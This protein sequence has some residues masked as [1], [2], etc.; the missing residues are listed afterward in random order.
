MNI[1]EIIE[2]KRDKEELTK[3]EI[4]YFVNEY[5]AGNIEDY[6]ASSLLMAIYLNGMVMR[7][8]VDLTI[9]MA[10]SSK[11]I[12]F[13]GIFDDEYVLD[14]HS[15]GGIGDK[16]SLIVIPIVASL[17]VKV[18]K[19]SGRGLGFTGGTADKLESIDGY[20]VEQDIEK[21]IRQVETIGACMITQSD[22]L[23]AADKKMYALR[24]VTGT[25]KSIPLIASSIMSKKIASGVDK[26]VL[27]IAVGTGAF[28]KGPKRARL[29]A[30][31]MVEIG[32]LAGKETVAVLAT[33]NE[34]I[35]TKVGNSLEIEEVIEFLLGDKYT[36]ESKA[37]KEMKEVVYEIAAHMLKLS[38][39]VE[40]IREGKVLVEKAILDRVAYK[41]FIEIVKA[42]GGYITNE[43][44]EGIDENVD[45][46]VISAK[47]T[48]M[49]EVKAD[50]DGYVNI[51]N[52]E[53]IGMALVELG[54]GRH[55][56]TDHIDYSVGFKFAKKIG[57]RVKKGDT[58]AYVYFN[59]KD[60][61]IRSMEE[62]LPVIKVES[63][64]PIV[65]PSIIEVID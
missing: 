64:M 63:I 33:M 50:K 62:L 28:M 39:V 4:E 55:K 1:I 14:K 19:M 16:I 26:I 10:N 18:F 47:A 43:Y 35:G 40:S 48:Y 22:E 42:Q 56:K 36:L 30:S 32:R 45:I 60:K 13:E 37:F 5:T 61:F 23:A 34:P 53:N 41:K 7:E 57:D 20:R 12:D 2:K 49:K 65:K 54:G 6:Q 27:E 25:I 59:D 51:Q 46:P 15:T 29:L 24:D 11:V 58:I 8:T 52:A 21:S 3:E 31:E 38:G 17:G 44:L 9:A